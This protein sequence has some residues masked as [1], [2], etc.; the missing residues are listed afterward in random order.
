MKNP[1]AA[2]KVVMEAVCQMLSVKPKKVNDPANPA[3]KIDDYW[4]PSQALL[5]DPAFLSKLQ[6]GC[7]PAVCCC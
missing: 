2:V 7:W 5:G 3:K 1:P 6:V 4:T